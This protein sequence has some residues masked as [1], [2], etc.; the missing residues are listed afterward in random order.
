MLKLL[1]FLFILFLFITIYSFKKRVDNIL[2]TLFPPKDKKRGFTKNEPDILVKCLNCG[3][4]VPK[5]DAVK[6]IKLNGEI[7]YFCSERCKK[8]YNS[9]R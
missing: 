5:Q 3:V 8:E 4:Y 6:K 1:F 9:K 2:D 7:L